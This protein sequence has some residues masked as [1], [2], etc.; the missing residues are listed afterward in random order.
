MSPVRSQSG[1]T[2]TL[3]RS[4]QATSGPS[5]AACV[6]RPTT[7]GAV[8]RCF[9]S[10]SSSAACT[11]RATLDVVQDQRAAGRRRQQAAV[12]V[13]AKEGDGG[14]EGPAAVEEQARR[15]VPV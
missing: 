11:S 8:P 12:A 2:G 6:V 9:S 14:R 15:V 5:A 3:A 13:G 4:S 1:G 7:S 10:Q